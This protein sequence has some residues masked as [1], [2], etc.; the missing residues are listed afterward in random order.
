VAL[1][2]RELAVWP[3]GLVPREASEATVAQAARLGRRKPT[4]VGAVPV[5]LAAP[6]ALAAQEL[7]RI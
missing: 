2:G 3:A 7:T 5:V 4:A 1:A 6:V